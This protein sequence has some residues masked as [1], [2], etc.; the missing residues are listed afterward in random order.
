[1]ISQWL[2]PMIAWVVVIALAVAVVGALLAE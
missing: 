1:M 2:A